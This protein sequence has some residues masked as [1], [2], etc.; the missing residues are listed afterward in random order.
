[1]YTEVGRGAAAVTVAGAGGGGFMAGFAMVLTGLGE[2]GG[3]SLR[4]WK[5]VHCG[6]KRREG[7]EER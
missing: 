3:V 4:S 5:L 1:M 2:G 6:E 7:K